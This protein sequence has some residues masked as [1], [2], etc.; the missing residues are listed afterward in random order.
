MN[1]RFLNIYFVNVL[2]LL[3]ICFLAE[4]IFTITGNYPNENADFSGINIWLIFLIYGIYQLG[5]FL[6]NDAVIFLRNFFICFILL[7]IISR[8]FTIFDFFYPKYYGFNTFLYD[9]VPAELGFDMQR[10]M[11]W[12]TGVASGYIYEK[13]AANYLITFFTVPPIAL[14]ECLIKAIFPNLYIILLLQLPIILIKRKTFS[15]TSK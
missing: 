7:F 8:Y 10:F 15:W 3:L 4:I 5:K 14:F 13:H 6:K 11:F 1:K 2:N 12:Q 9:F